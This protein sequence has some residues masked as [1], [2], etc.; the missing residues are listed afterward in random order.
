MRRAWLSW[1]LMR[2][3]FAWLALVCLGMGLGLLPV[4]PSG[5]VWGASVLAVTFSAFNGAYEIVLDQ[6]YP[7]ELNRLCGRVLA[8]GALLSLAVCLLWRA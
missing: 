2:L 8:L 3:C 6:D 5:A 4:L 7:D 1:L